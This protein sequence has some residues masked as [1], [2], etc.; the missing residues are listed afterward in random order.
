MGR[1]SRYLTRGLFYEEMGEEMYFCPEGPVFSS[2]S[3]PSPPS[4]PDR[5][6]GNTVV[7][8]AKYTVDLI[9][10]EREICED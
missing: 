4:I 5:L 7:F 9:H 8:P 3:T 6:P 1:H 10:R 2:A